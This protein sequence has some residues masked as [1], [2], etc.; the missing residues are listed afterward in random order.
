MIKINIYTFFFIFFRGRGEGFSI[1]V[2]LR[3]GRRDTKSGSAAVSVA[4]S[5]QNPNVV[6]KRA[7]SCQTLPLA[8]SLWACQVTVERG[9][10]LYIMT[11]TLS[12]LLTQSSAAA[13]QR[14]GKLPTFS[15]L[16]SVKREQ[17]LIQYLPLLRVL[18]PLGVTPRLSPQ[19]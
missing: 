10:N 5:E 7:L 2:Q 12:S 8:C 19:C 6:F 9:S 17:N 18:I 16:A 15:S 14:V 1:L 13:D 4:N 11:S 3:N